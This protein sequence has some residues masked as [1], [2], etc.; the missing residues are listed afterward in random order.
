ML[1]RM[2]EAYDETGDT[3]QAI[4]LGL[5]RTGKLV[6]SAALVLMFA[7]F[8]LSTS[9]G[10]DIKQFGIGLAAGIIFDATV[11]RALLVPSIMRLMGDWNWWMPSAW[12]GFSA[13]SQAPPDSRRRRR[14]RRRRRRARP[15]ADL[16]ARARARARRPRAR[17]QLRARRTR[18]PGR[19]GRAG[20]LGARDRVTASAPSGRSCAPTPPLRSRST[21]AA[22]GW[23]LRAPARA[24]RPLRRASRRTPHGGRRP[25]TGPARQPSWWSTKW[26]SSCRKLSGDPAV[27]P[28]HA[29]IDGIALPHPVA[30]GLARRRGRTDGNGL[31][32]RVQEVERVALPR[33][34]GR[35]RGR[36]GCGG[37]A[38]T[39]S[40]AGA[41]AAHRSGPRS[42]DACV[43]AAHRTQATA[44]GGRS[45]YA[46]CASSAHPAGPRAALLRLAVRAPRGE[47]E[48]AGARRERDRAARRR[49]QLSGLLDAARR[50]HAER[51]LGRLRRARP[52]RRQDQPLGDDAAAASSGSGA[53]TRPRSPA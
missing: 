25:R 39:S 52:A 53:A 28:R 6:T 12:P 10:T 8:V 49:R 22:T 13:S 45:R 19:A 38:A 16:A 17:T 37:A 4:S 43:S 27:P 36:A 1:T 41:A 15:G 30:A 21:G 18:R 50:D 47:R 7:F 11:I 2:R 24:A 51:R 32:V 3:N 42:R 9:P 35:A 48:P 23:S 31:E 26:P 33:A 14:L 44:Q 46:V 34:R 5:A 40:A 20:G 29:Q